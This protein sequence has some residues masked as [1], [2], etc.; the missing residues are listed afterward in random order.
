MSRGASCIAGPHDHYV[1]GWYSRQA[2]QYDASPAVRCFQEASGN[3]WNQHAGDFTHCGDHG[4]IMVI[5]FHELQSDTNDMLRPE[6]AMNFRIRGTQ[7]YDTEEEFAFTNPLAFLQ[8]G[9]HDLHDDVRAG[10]YLFSRKSDC[11]SG[12]PVGLGGKS[13]AGSGIGLGND[14]V[15]CL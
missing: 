15:A 5:V 13:D 10:K 4:H 9:R 6:E 14:G 8:G 7:V 11:S 2:S 1:G 3:L 12:F